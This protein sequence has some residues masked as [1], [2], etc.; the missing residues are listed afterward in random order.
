M[1]SPV[2]LVMPGA[3]MLPR[4]PASQGSKLHASAPIW[5]FRP[6]L[7]RSE[8]QTA[9]LGNLSHRYEAKISW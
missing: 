9:F 1:D 4:Q 6:K 8:H 5:F 7:K 2:I 3:N